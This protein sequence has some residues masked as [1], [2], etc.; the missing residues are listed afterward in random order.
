MFAC[1]GAP[2]ASTHATCVPFNVWEVLNGST[3]RHRAR[4]LNWR[5]DVVAMLTL[6][7]LVLP[8]YH[9]YRTLATQR[10]PPVAVP[11]KP[12]CPAT[13]VLIG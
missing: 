12:D 6:L 11:Y 1:F 7:L 2:T 13:S 5:L 8:Y 9:C 3:F 10:K 4:W